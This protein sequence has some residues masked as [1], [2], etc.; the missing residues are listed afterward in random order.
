MKPLK[1]ACLFLACAS[2]LIGQFGC[3]TTE[4]VANTV[5]SSAQFDGNALKTDKA[6]KAEAL[7]LIARAKN[8]APYTD[9]AADVDK[10]MAKVDQAIATEQGR[11]KNAPTV[12]QW[13]KIKTQLSSLFNLWKS[14]GSVSPAFADDAGSQI[15]GLFDI[16]IKT[17]ND[18]PKQS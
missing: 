2:L 9:V 7:A 3:A 16:L 13:K 18:K 5:L 11:P 6:I 12:A 17:E 15:G 8:H 14:K 10:L 4:K 1:N